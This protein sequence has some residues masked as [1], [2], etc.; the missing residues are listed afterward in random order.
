MLSFQWSKCGLWVIQAGLCA[1]FSGPSTCSEKYIRSSC[2]RGQSV[3]SFVQFDKVEGSCLPCFPVGVGKTASFSTTP[4]HSP[5]EKRQQRD[6]PS[7]W[8]PVGFVS[9]SNLIDVFA[10]IKLS[11]KTVQRIYI[12]F[13]FACLYNIVG[14][15]VAAGELVLWRCA[16]QGG[17]KWAD[18]FPSS[19]GLVPTQLELASNPCCLAGRRDQSQISKPGMCCR[20]L[21]QFY[22]ACRS[23]VLWVPDVL[24]VIVPDEAP[25]CQKEWKPWILWLRCWSL[26]MCSSNEAGRAVKVWD[27][28]TVGQNLFFWGH[29]P[30][31]SRTCRHKR[32]PHLQ[33]EWSECIAC[34]LH[35]VARN[36]DFHLCFDEFCS[37]QFTEHLISSC[38]NSF[39]FARKAS[40][41]RVVS[42][43]L[44]EWWLCGFVAGVFVPWGLSLKPWMASAAMAAS[45]V[46]VVV[47]SLFLRL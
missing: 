18:R 5:L 2:F 9:Q 1:D 12:N 23:H 26:S 21:C 36:S 35:Q 11:R 45:S 4:V 40:G 42:P 7:D 10:A 30:C 32:F 43:S 31:I 24:E 15:P 33:V 46:S 20:M 39:A 47:S 41:S 3:G 37:A 29:A 14:I 34:L 44:I 25:K 27:Q 28:R 6:G 13:F 19:R 22:F 16:A 8:W 38:S 17:W